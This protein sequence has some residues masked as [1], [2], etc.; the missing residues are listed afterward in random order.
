[1][2][3]NQRRLLPAGSAASVV[4]AVKAW[5][6]ACPVLPRGVTVSF[7]DLKEDA[8][9]VCFSTDQSAAYAARYV[10]GGYRAEYQFRIICRVLPTD[11]G[12]M[13]DAVELLTAISAWCET[14]APPEI[15]GA[16]NEKITRTSDAA[17]LAVY[18]DGCSD[19][20]TQ[21]TLTWEV[22]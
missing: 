10:T 14:A 21:L 12:D 16:V 11:D 18:E 8:F 1:M 20:G 19:Y 7:E 22:I 15:T 13:L 4:R 5:I 9:G 6:N 3:N 2:A 17:I